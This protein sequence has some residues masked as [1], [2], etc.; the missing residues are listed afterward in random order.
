MLALEEYGY[1]RSEA[2]QR[3]AGSM[4]DPA[5]VSR[6]LQKCYAYGWLILQ[7]ALGVLLA[8]VLTVSVTELFGVGHSL[9]YNLQARFDP[10]AHMAESVR[11][12]V[13]EEVDYRFACGNSVVRIY[14]LGENERGELE[15]HWCV[16]NETPFRYAARNIGIR[17]YTAE[18]RE[19]ELRAGGGYFSNSTVRY[20]NDHLELPEGAESVFVEVSWWDEAETVEIPITWEVGA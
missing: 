18:D 4:G 11:E 7:R 19:T 15:V 17:Y 9:F 6:E 3:A 14:A 2:E 12:R 13:K 20:G 10:M 16:R 1:E 8:L 5:E